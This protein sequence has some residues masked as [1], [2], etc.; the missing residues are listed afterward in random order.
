MIAILFWLATNSQDLTI[1]STVIRD[2]TGFRLP[3]AT[4]G[5]V[6]DLY[7]NMC[8]YVPTIFVCR[9]AAPQVPASPIFSLQ[10][11]PVPDPVILRNNPIMM[12]FDVVY[13][14]LHKLLYIQ[15]CSH[16][17]M[18]MLYRLFL[19]LILHWKK[20]LLRINKMILAFKMSKILMLKIKI[21]NW[22][23]WLVIFMITLWL[24]IICKCLL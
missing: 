2:G 21:L 14:P 18:Y 22:V 23:M 15:S 20:V 8:M 3:S 5:Y 7:T 9:S 11:E 16:Y 6:N 13:T 19:H 17:F 10:I 4:N 12:M 24:L 1:S